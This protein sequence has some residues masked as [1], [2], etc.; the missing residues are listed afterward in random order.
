MKENVERF[1]ICIVGASIAGNFLGYLLSN[2]N[3]RI[4]IIEEHD[5]IGLPF[6][7]AGIVSQKLAKLIKLDDSLVL[8]RVKV[9]RLVAPSGK[10]ITLSGNEEP[11]IIDRIAL[12]RWFYDKI[13][14]NPNIKYFLE[15]KF[16]KFEY[17]T[18]NSS[19]IVLI[20]TSKRKLKAKILVGCDGPL[21]SVAHSLKIRNRVLYA[22][23]IRIKANFSKN[24]AL[25]YFNKRWKELFGWVVPE[26]DNQI[27]RVGLACSKNV[28]KNFKK[29]LKLI[30]VNID[31]KIDQ[32]G[33]LIP[34]G[35]LNKMA[36][37]N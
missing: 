3:L 10:T 2:S 24:E 34:Y 17:S 8:N 31:D 37:S 11:Y 33:G 13:K 36:F 28:N 27:Y 15:E 35:K 23:Q 7:C 16:Q 18:E 26:G 29:F 4:A 21:S 20:T 22:T 5:A 1:D 25:M 9:A 12:D 19:K 14:E 6:Q 32:Q 30:N